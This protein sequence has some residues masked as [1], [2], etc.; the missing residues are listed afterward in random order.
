MQF[1]PS[2]ADKKKKKTKGK[3][4]YALDNEDIFGED[5]LEGFMGLEV[6]HGTAILHC[7]TG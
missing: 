4:S 5:N 1:Y 6:F 7:I 2:F 3:W